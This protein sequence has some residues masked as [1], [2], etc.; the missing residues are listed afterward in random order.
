MAYCTNAQVGEELK[1]LTFSASTVPTDTVVDR[2]IGEA[3]EL[4][5]S[6]VG[7]KY[8]VPI[9]VGTSP[10][11]FK[12]MTSTSIM[13][14]AD[15][16]KKHQGRKDTSGADDSKSF[17]TDTDRMMKRLKDI[18]DGTMVLSDASLISTTEGVSSFNVSNS[19]KHT[20]KKGTDA[21]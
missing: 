3:D 13:L 5:D 11:A 7:K 21:W 14:V 10:K 12:I 20:F 19:E 6:F 15:R 18:Y 9:V 4:I 16:V 2:W 1:G 17:R 8:S